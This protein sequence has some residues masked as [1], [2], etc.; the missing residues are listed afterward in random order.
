VTTTVV[1]NAAWVA[2]FDAEWG[3]HVYL[4]DADVVLA[5]DR[6]VHVGPDFAG[7]CDV[8]IDGRRRFVMPGLVNVHSHPLSEPM[9][10]GFLHE[11]GSPG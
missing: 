3:E 10:K 4:R 7:P 2:A 5:G 6:I 8:E 1:H 9:N 11:P